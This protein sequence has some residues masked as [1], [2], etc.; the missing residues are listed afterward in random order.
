MVKHQVVKYGPPWRKEEVLLAIALYKT[1]GVRPDDKDAKVIELSQL[2]GRTAS[3]VALK[4]ANLRAVE[5]G[6]RSGLSHLG[7]L[8][9]QV[10]EEFHGRDDALKEEAAKLRIE[11]ENASSAQ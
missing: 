3:A 8:D 9:K 2:I 10:W 5:T 4:L 7:P 11:F 1:P 6:G